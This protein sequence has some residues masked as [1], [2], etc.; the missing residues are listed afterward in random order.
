MKALKRTVMMTRLMVL[1]MI[2]ALIP[3]YGDPV[4]AA[5]NDHEVSGVDEIGIQT[6]YPVNDLASEE[7]AEEEE[8]IEIS[9]EEFDELEAMGSPVKAGSRNSAFVNGLHHGYFYN[10]LSEDGKQIYDAALQIADE[11]HIF[12]DHEFLSRKNY[13]GIFNLKGARIVDNFTAFLEAREALQLDHAEN[14][15]I[16][17]TSLREQTLYSGNRRKSYVYF[18]GN[19][20]LNPYTKTNTYDKTQIDAIIAARNEILAGV[21]LNTA[22]ELIELQIH[23]ALINRTEYKSDGYKT[24][25]DIY[26][27]LVH[28]KAVCAGYSR[29]F[30]YL[31]NY[32]G[33]PTMYIR[34]KAGGTSTNGNHAWNIVLIGGKW[35]EVDCTWDDQPK[36]MHLDNVIHDYFNL[37]TAEM[38]EHNVLGSG[39]VK[40]YHTRDESIIAPIAYGTKY[41]YKALKS[42]VTGNSYR[43][44]LDVNGEGATI[45]QTTAIAYDGVC[46]QLPYPTRKDYVFTGWYT[47]AFGGTKI[48][49]GKIFSGPTTLYAHWDVIKEFTIGDISYE[50]ISSSQVKV[51]AV[52]NISTVIIPEM[53]EYAGKNLYVKA[54]GENAFDGTTA[55]KK[56]DIQALL[57]TVE[58]G[59]FRGAK[60]VN[61]IIFRYG[62]L[63][64][65][66]AY[67]ALY[68]ISGAKVILYYPSK[69]LK[70]AVM[71]RWNV[72]CVIR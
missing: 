15:V 25:Q 2:I 68:D 26:G 53:V 19:G 55:V 51:T 3:V 20:E 18:Y 22:P 39:K 44:T 24:D 37:T 72:K 54:I 32:V 70:K 8:C 6:S 41:T 61:K 7:T 36:S 21:N 12:K 34:G 43:I 62:G 47:K 23:D 60:H 66:V 28:R 63:V 14:D 13:T 11:E 50:M 35:Y 17:F 67:N 1:C 30:S 59:A 58:E 64:K 31:M 45:G 33:I 56:I 27:A 49:S 4:Y 52:S 71:D 16:A 65:S 29:A 48:T 42:G 57:Y 10:G 46:C 9:A 38:K 40:T 5:Q 69:K